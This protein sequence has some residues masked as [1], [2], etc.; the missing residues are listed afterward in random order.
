MIDWGVQNHLQK[1][2][3]FRFHAPILRF[4]EPASLGIESPATVDGRNPAPVDGN[5]GNHHLGYC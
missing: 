3:Y 1:T 2:W 5:N 4:G